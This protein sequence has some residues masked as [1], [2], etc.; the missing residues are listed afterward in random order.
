[1]RHRSARTVVGLVS[2]VLFLIAWQIV[3]A[4]DIIRSDLISYPSEIAATL[5]QMSASGELG[6]NVA[7]SLQEFV[8]GFV[9]AVAIGIAAGTAFALSRR[10][11]YLF[12]PL[13][14]ALNTSP[15]HRLRAGRGGVVRG[16]HPIQSHHGVSRRRRPDRHQHHDG[17][18]PSA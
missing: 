16:R 17:H 6:S 4:N 1:M 13:I 10:L 7:V 12:E 5:V 11:H 14:V 18:Q 2:V 3:G 8:Q 15:D 9:P